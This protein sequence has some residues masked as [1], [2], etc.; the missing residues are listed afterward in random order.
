MEEGRTAGTSF[1]QSRGK[2]MAKTITRREVLKTGLTAAS[3]AAMGLP[4]WTLPGMAQGETVVPFTDIP[5]TV[6]F[7][8][9]NKSVTRV[10]DIRNV[11]ETFTAEDTFFREQYI[12]D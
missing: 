5:D 1:M 9:D 11:T 7:T 12:V 8:L 4:E 10:L 3:L 2:I 6:S